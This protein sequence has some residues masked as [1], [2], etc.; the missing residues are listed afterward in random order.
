MLTNTGHTTKHF[1]FD[2]GISAKFKAAFK[3][4]DKTFEQVPPH[5]HHHNA[6]K[7]AIRTFKNH[8]L[9]G[10]ATCDNDFL[11]A[12]WDRLVPQANLMLNLLQSA[13]IN[14]KLS[15]HAYIFG[16][17]NF[18]STPLAQLG[19]KVII[20]KKPE[21]MVSFAYHG[22]EGFTTAPST[23]HY[24]CLKCFVPS[25][26]AAIDCDMLELLSSHVPIPQ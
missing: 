24:Q 13:R 19:S 4:Y 9:A 10:L 15:A 25:T 16:S 20:H 21:Q 18:N 26:G 22:V 2:N 6:A 7:R 3:K 12:E 17:H 5:I 11:I 14:P 23:E 1:V 8:L